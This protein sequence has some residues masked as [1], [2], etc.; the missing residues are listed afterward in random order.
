MMNQAVGIRSIAVNFP[1]IVRTNDYW[2]ENYPELIA[3][4]E[5]KPLAKL[6]SVTDPNAK[7][8]EFDKQMVPYLSDPFRGAVERRIVAPH[9]SSLTLEKRAASDAM[10]AAEMSPSDVDLLIVNTLSCPERISPGNAA[11]LVAELGLRCPAWNIESGCS[12]ASV[13]LHTANALVNSGQYRNV[14]IVTSCIHS[15]FID[16]DDSLS[17]FMGDGAGAFVVG[18]LKPNQGILGTKIINT[19]ATCG[20]CFHELIIDSQGN[21]QMRFRTG[22][23][24]SQQIRGTGV[25]FVHACSESALAAAGLTLDDIKLFAFSTPTA[26]YAKMSADALGIPLERTIN[27][28]PQYGNIGPVLPI[29]SLYH[30]AQSG[31]IQENDLV[32]VYTIGSASNAVATVMRW[33]D[34][35]L[36]P[37]PAP[38]ASSNHPEKTPLFTS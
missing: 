17:W 9:E 12:S 5:Q 34:V 31:Q 28:Y 13:S 21:P 8:R 10:I 36:G 25:E 29:A 6:F 26:W 7:T 2:R 32:L 27:L 37:L 20:A 38:G 22:L 14:L 23:N 30:A 1:S 15:R 19:A 18:A 4:A 24:A 11:F 16:E 3:K 33:G 35:K